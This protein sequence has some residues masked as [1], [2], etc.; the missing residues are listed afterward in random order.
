M[1]SAAWIAVLI[2]VLAGTGLGYWLAQL[3]Q[4]KNNSG[5]SV[6]ELRAE[7]EQFRDQVTE[8]FAETAQLVNQL[9]DSYKAVFDHLSTGARQLTDS[10]KLQ[11]RL[12]QIDASAVTIQRV[13]YDAPSATGN[14]ATEASPPPTSQAQSAAAVK[15]QP[16]QDKTAAQPA[17]DKR[18]NNKT[19]AGDKAQKSSAQS[20]R[21][22]RKQR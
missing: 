7:Q 9:T 22:G 17:S 18:G 6:R 21:T 20:H 15:Q 4:R 11:Q 16:A 14:A 2:A 3:S 10:E 13:G 8:H 1:N 12:P 5:K 19:D